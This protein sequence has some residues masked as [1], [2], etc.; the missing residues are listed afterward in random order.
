MKEG[1]YIEAKIS[2]KSISAIITKR[3]IKKWIKNT[4][5]KEYYRQK[6]NIIVWKN[7]GRQEYCIISQL[8]Y[9]VKID[10][11]ASSEDGLTMIIT[12]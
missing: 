2:Y 3:K 4:K 1:S 6:N 12:T 7:I 9:V 10:G 11:S 8:R 5:K